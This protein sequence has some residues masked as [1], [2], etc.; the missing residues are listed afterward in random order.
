ME[1]IYLNPTNLAHWQKR[2]RTSVIALGFFDGIHKG[3]RLVIET[4]VQKAKEKNLSLSVMSFFPH[5]KTILSNGKKRVD[6]LL[7]L[8]EKEKMLQTLGVDT[9]YI[10]EFDKDF[11][12]L[13]PEQFVTKYLIGLGVVHAVAGF[14]YTYGS[15]GAGNMDRLKNDSG[16]LLDV[17]KVSKVEW[18]GQKISSSCIREKL[19]KGYVEELPNYLG[20]SYT[21]KG[22]WDGTIFK[23]S[24]YYTLPAPGSYAVTLKNEMGS[25]QTEVVVMKKHEDQSL[26]CTKKIP[27]FME[28]NLSIVW[29]SQIRVEAVKTQN[30]KTNVLVF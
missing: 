16:G 7:P 9:F 26:K 4:A 14:D 24:P 3:H 6:Y 5:P 2:A 18:C 21:V 12:S 23:L 28:G 19:S 30:V 20:Y 22:D 11:A 25:I 8:S 29:H 15:L 27:T 10:I 13:S 17:T 1:T